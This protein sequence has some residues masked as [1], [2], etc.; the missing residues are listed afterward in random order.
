M[1]HK[2]ILLFQRSDWLPKRWLT[3]HLQAAKEKQNGFLFCFGFEMEI[4]LVNEE[5][6]LKN[7]KLATKFGSTVLH[8]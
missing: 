8:G 3:K 5:V 2:W 4:I 7:T 1:P 6:V